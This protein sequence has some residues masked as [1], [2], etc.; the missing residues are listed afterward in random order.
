MSGEWYF[1]H[2]SVP[3][4]KSGEWYFK[5]KSVPAEK[6]GEWYFKPKSV[7]AEN[8]EQD[9]DENDFQC[10]STDLWDEMEND[11]LQHL[12][13]MLNAEFHR[14]NHYSHMHRRRCRDYSNHVNCYSWFHPMYVGK[15]ASVYY[16]NLMNIMQKWQK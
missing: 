4:E 9:C 10:V 1:K 12:D 8:N 6:S 13:K 11:K 2:K 14:L 15:W 5:H 3:A 16:Q 7:S